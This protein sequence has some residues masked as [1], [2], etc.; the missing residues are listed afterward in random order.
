[1]LKRTPSQALK[2]K[3]SH[4]PHKAENTTRADTMQKLMPKRVEK[5]F[6]GSKTTRRGNNG[7]PLTDI[8]KTLILIINKRM[9]PKYQSP[10]YAITMNM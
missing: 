1:M 2:I 4:N 5:T 10:F 9:P 3:H 6:Q 7:Q 8:K